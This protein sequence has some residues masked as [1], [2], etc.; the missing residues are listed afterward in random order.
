MNAIEYTT[1]SGETEKNAEII[2]SKCVMEGLII[3]TCEADDKVIHRTLQL[4]IDYTHLVEVLT[5]S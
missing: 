5:F 2:W 3:L 4:K 1:P